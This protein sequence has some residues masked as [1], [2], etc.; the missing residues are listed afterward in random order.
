MRVFV[1]SVPK[2]P[3][4]PGSPARNNAVEIKLEKEVLIFRASES[5]RNRIEDLLNKRKEV[6]LSESEKNEL[7]EY[8][9]IDDYLIYLNRLTRN[10]AE[11]PDKDVS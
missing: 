4:L 3:H 8:E 10:F 6:S 1:E 5:I 7:Q 9:E 2:L 11:S